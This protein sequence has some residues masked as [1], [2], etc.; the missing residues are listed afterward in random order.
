M[1]SAIITTYNRAEFLKDALQSVLEQDYPGHIQVIVCNDGSTD[2]TP[3]V[4]DHYKGLFEKQ[5]NILETVTDL[6]TIEQRR[7]EVRYVKMINKALPLCKEKYIS[8]LTDD[9]LWHPKRT[10]LMVDYLESHKDVYLVYHFMKVFQ[11]GMDKEFH[12]QIWDLHQEWG[13]G[14][15]YWIENI[16][17]YIDHCSVMH[18]NLH[19]DNILWDESFAYLRCGD[20]GFIK[21]AL[22]LGKEFAHIP[23][24]LAIGRKIEGMSVHFGGVDKYLETVNAH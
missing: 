19:T 14:L 5:G 2:K 17:N 9:D 15:K 6:P 12:R 8:Y 10:S 18:R 1:L 22:A 21:K 7:T 3:E 24:Y 13:P 16:W 20:W 4:I 11:V 23:T